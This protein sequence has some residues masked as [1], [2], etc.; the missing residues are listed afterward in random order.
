MLLS[1]REAANIGRGARIRFDFECYD[2]V[3]MKDLA[4]VAIVL[5]L[6]TFGGGV[7]AQCTRV[8]SAHDRYDY[9]RFPEPAGNVKKDS[10]PR[11][12][13]V[14]TVSVHEMSIPNKAREA[15]NKAVQQFNANDWGKSILNAQRAIGLAPAFYEAYNLL[16]LAEACLDSWDLAEAAYRRSIELSSDTFASPHFGLGL[17]LSQRKQFVEAEATI[18]E[19]LRLDPVDAKGYFSLA[20]AQY[21]AGR[22]PEAERSA[23]EA[24]RYKS[25]YAAPYVLLA[26]IDQLQG[27]PAA[28]IED[29]K[30]YLKLQPAGP[31]NTEARAAL[32]D[33]ERSLEK[34]NT[35][36][37]TKP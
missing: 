32:A 4:R 29:L 37:P 31:L 11:P 35:A 7:L 18:L 17:A 10:P 8:G 14:G 20:A 16:G 9:P 27:N 34:Q 13:G 23:R 30:N 28:E 12:A 33:A 3:G 1:E 19:G 25:N 5:A 2:R 22:F 6:L 36:M 21:L 24:I 26:E 15:Y